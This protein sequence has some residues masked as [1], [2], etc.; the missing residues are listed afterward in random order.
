M[1]EGVGGRGREQGQEKALDP[2]TISLDH[3]ELLRNIGSGGYGKV[4]A[5]EKV[6]APEKG[7]MFGR[8]KPFA[9]RN[10]AHAANLDA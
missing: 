7:T 6:A 9:L 2:N 1:S 4:R 5:V 10:S 8:W 3:F